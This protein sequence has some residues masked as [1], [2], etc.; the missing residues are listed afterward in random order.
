MTTGNFNRKGCAPRQARGSEAVLSTSNHGAGRR[1]RPG[2]DPPLLP[3]GGCLLQPWGGRRPFPN[4]PYIRALPRS[5]RAGQHPFHPRP[6]PC[7]PERPRLVLGHHGLFQLSPESRVD[8]GQQRPK[9]AQQ[10]SEDIP[11]A[12]CG[13]VPNELHQHTH[14][15]RCDHRR[16]EKHGRWQPLHRELRR[17]ARPP[18][19]DR[20]GLVRVALAESALEALLAGVLPPIGLGGAGAALRLVPLALRLS[21]Q[22]S[23]SRLNALHVARHIGVH[24][25]ERA[26]HVEE[27]L[28]EGWRR[29]TDGMHWEYRGHV[30]LERPRHQQRATHTRAAR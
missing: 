6:A 30:V 4:P 24:L 19:V 27:L 25:S 9:G 29:Q 16:P 13:D 18:A 10:G 21:L 1:G 28:L 14:I 5:G 23:R 15:R 26:V 7:P 3:Q 8:D 17:E 12:R 2:R 11:V 22:L 20:D